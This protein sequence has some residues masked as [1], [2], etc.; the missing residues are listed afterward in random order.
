MSGLDDEL[1]DRFRLLRDDDRAGAPAF[2][3]TWDAA[4]GRTPTTT[5][6]RLNPVFAL[7]AAAGVLLAVGLAFRAARDRDSARQ[8]A[9]S[10]VSSPLVAASITTWTSPTAGLLRT[11]GSELLGTPSLRTSILDRVV[12]APVQ[13]RGNTP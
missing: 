11:S 3:E 9:D 6:W 10:T 4:A 2:R 8:L 7:A 5:P 12:P 1:R 13:P